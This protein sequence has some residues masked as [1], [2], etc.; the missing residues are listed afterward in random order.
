MLGDGQQDVL[1]VQGEDHES[2]YS[3]RVH[4]HFAGELSGRPQDFDAKLEET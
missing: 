2:R 4:G 3:R 1:R